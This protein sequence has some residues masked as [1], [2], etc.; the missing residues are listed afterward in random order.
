MINRT[1]DLHGKSSSYKSIVRTDI[2]NTF[3]NA[4]QSVDYLS[5]N[6]TKGGRI[7]S[8][9]GYI[10]SSQITF[11][12]WIDDVKIV[13][14]PAIYYRWSIGSIDGTTSTLKKYI[15]VEM[16]RGVDFKN[17]FKIVLRNPL[18]SGVSTTSL[19]MTSVLSVKE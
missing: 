17:S 14:S 9:R 10:E 11:E 5:F 4:G 3:L 2:L 19:C 8:I 7:E 15:G 18:D 12:I 1:R 6:S 13:D 16:V